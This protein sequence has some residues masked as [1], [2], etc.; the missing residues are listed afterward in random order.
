MG[1]LG[2][3]V[4]GGYAILWDSA[5]LGLKVSSFNLLQ[6]LVLGGKSIDLSSSNVTSLVLR[7]SALRVLAG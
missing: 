7:V 1:S 4:L 5:M 3:S 2:G 6:Y